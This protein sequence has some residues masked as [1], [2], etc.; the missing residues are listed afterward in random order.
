MKTKIIIFFKIQETYL[1]YLHTRDAHTQFLE[2]KT[3][4][5]C[6]VQRNKD[7]RKL[8]SFVESFGH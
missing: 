8:L 7:I 6:Y 2:K 1:V 4:R 5:K 3:I